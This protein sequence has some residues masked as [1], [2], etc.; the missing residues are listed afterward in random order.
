[1]D[2]E[3]KMAA[4]I[5][6]LRD[7]GVEFVGCYYEGGGD[8]GAIDQ[9]YFFDEEFSMKWDDDFKLDYSDNGNMDTK[10][11]EKLRLNVETKLE[12][13]FY[14]ELNTIED[15]WNNDGGYGS[16]VLNLQTM[17]F[18]IDNNLRYTNTEVYIHDGSVEID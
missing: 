7:N 8:S 16:M 1:M 12:D 13:L 4:V 6:E 14:R 10:L 9:Y 2:K 3:L 18:K 5:A 17:E 11:S 15:W